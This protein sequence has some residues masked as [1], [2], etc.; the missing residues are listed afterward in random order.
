MRS[1]DYLIIGQGLAGSVLAH[2]MRQHQL[3]VMVVDRPREGGASRVAAGVV[4]PVSL[5][6]LT[7]SWRA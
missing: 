5:R 3:Q 7:K 2:T 6:R 4:N 1:V